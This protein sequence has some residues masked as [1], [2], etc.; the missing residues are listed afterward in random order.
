MSREPVSRE[1]RFP[2][3]FVLLAALCL[4]GLPFIAVADPDPGPVIRF[5]QDAPAPQIAPAYAARPGLPSP[6]PDDT[7]SDEFGL[8][9]AP[10]SANLDATDGAA[11]GRVSLGQGLNGTVWA[12]ASV[13]D[14]IYAG[15]A[16]T[17]AGIVQANAI[18]RWDGTAWHRLAQG[19]DGIVYALAEYHGQLYAGGT[20]EGH[21]AIGRR[22]AYVARWDGTS[23]N[24]VGGGVNGAVRAFA[25][26]DGNLVAAGDFLDAGGVPASGIAAWDGLGWNRL[27]EA[28][29]ASVQDT[30]NVRALVAHRDRLYAGGFFTRAGGVPAGYVAS[31]DGSTWSSLGSGLHSTGYCL[32]EYRGDLIAGSV[33][34]AGPQEGS[35]GD[36]VSRWDGSNWLPLGNGT[37]VPP[38]PNG[39]RA[40]ADLG[41]LLIAVGQ[42]QSAASDPASNMAGW[43]GSAWSRFGLG[44]NAPAYAV[45]GH[46]GSIYV[47]G[48]FTRAGNKVSL[49]IAR[50]IIPVV[51]ARGAVSRPPDVLRVM[52]VEPARVQIEYTLT[53]TAHAAM[54]EVF[55]LSGRLVQTLA[56]A[57]AAGD[58]TAEWNRRDRNGMDAAAGMYFIRLRAEPT[59]LHSKV[60]LLPR[61]SER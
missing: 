30:L 34:W 42:F 2:A 5:D 36:L 15:G 9:A 48:D 13:G 27:G 39:V 31:W 1:A 8:N 50:W 44:L 49:H 35:W 7:W 56:V 11:W 4:T 20:F 53:E 22:F 29:T 19:L 26:Y 40:M 43:N 51:G 17:R 14:D 32:A 55:D 16:F 45:I 12:L 33:V 23:W 46:R 21:D 52:G 3:R 61:G 41:G 57:A 60:L 28:L 37:L 59:V 10:N 54:L 25:V 47:G 24:A 38:F 6:S 58:H 18:A